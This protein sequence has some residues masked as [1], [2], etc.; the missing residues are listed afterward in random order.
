MLFYKKLKYKYCLN[1]QKCELSQ[2]LIVIV[3]KLFSLYEKGFVIISLK[4]MLIVSKCIVIYDKKLLK[5]R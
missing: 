4:L 3:S 5:R 1:I 2:C